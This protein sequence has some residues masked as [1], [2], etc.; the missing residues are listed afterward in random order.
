MKIK[1]KIK[2]YIAGPMRGI[3]NFNRDAFDE[4]EM[5]LLKKGVYETVNP[6]SLDEES[7]LTDAELVSHDGLRKIMHRDLTELLGCNAIYMLK[8]WEK[9]EGSRVEH[10]LATMVG[11]YIQYQ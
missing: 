2:I 3:K 9:S 1:S 4:A 8:G 5:N 6:V 11:M 10:G 7:G